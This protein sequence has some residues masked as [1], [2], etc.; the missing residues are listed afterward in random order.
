ML[1]SEDGSFN[2]DYVDFSPEVVF[3][4]ACWPRVGLSIN[5]PVE[6]LKNNIISG[7]VLLNFSRK[8]GSVKRVIYSSSSSVIGN[9]HGPTN[10]YALQKYITELEMGMYSKLYGLD[11]VSLRYFNVYSHDQIDDELYPTFVANWMQGIRD[12]KRLFITG[13]G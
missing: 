10:P 3:H 8:V 6:T 7:S 5:R 2:P 12:K 13:D 4:M 9:G 1:E 11:T